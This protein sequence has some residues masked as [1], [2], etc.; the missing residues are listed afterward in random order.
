[1]SKQFGHKRQHWV[2]RS[3]LSA[4]ID[5]VRPEG[6]EPF[7]HLFSRDGSTH[8]RRAPSNIFKET[9]LYTIKQPDGG[10][11][12]RLERGLSGLEESFV[13]IRKEFL[14]KR[15]QLPLVRRA[16]LILFVAAMH[17]RTPMMRDHHGEFWR[18]VQDIG[19][20]VERWMKTATPE[21]KKRAASI[22][23][24][25]SRDGKSMSMDD[26]RKITNSPMEHTL[27][28][29]VQAEAPLLGMMEALI[30]C[31]NNKPGFI[32]SDT[33]VVWYDADAYRRPPLLRAPAFMHPG[34]EITMPISPSQ[35]LLLRHAQE[36]GPVV[37]YL[38]DSSDILVKEMNRRTRHHCRSGFVVAS[39]YID[40]IWL[41]SGT[42]PDDAWEKHNP[43]MDERPED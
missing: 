3:Y 10:R 7:V 39:N 2:P 9:D 1:M 24:L 34:L 18:R 13:A 40:P 25:G 32:T 36:D 30:F 12:L 27:I 5:P 26:V 29:M 20:E 16:K 28:P 37:M 43:E 6:H 11:D 41:D 15:K 42:L 33:P 22:P 17:S 35:L 4:W 38:D 23:T 21:E 19:E 31:T 8:E 14:A